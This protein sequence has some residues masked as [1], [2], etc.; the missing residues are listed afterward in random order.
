MKMPGSNAFIRLSSMMLLAMLLQQC[1]E[2]RMFEEPLSK[3]T[4][5]Y[6]IRSRFV[7][8]THTIHGRQTLEWT[9]TTA[10]PARELRFHLYMNAFKDSSATFWREAGGFPD[11]LRENRGYCL[12]KLVL[13]EDFGDVT[14][15][16]VFIQ[17]DDT[18]SHDQ[19]VVALPLRKELK[20]GQ[21]IT[22]RIEFETILPPLIERAGHHG[23]FHIAAQWYPK[24]GVYTDDG[25]RCHQYHANGEFFADFGV[26]DVVLSVPHNYEIGSTGVLRNIPEV[27]EGYKTYRLYAEDVHDFV[28][29]ADTDFQVVRRRI[30]NLRVRLLVRSNHVGEVAERILT[31]VEHGYKHFSQHVGDYPYPV[32]TVVDAPVFG[33]V[34]EYPTLFF[35]GNFDGY[36]NPPA[37]DK[38]QP[39]DNLFMERLTLHELGHQWFYGM[40]ANNEAR[41]A[42][43]D[44]GLTEYITARAFETKYGRI[45]QPDPQGKPLPVRHFRLDRYQ[46]NA[47]QIVAQPSWYYPTFGD[48]YIGSYVKPKLFLHTL[49]N[50]LGDERVPKAVQTFFKRW[51]FKHPTADDFFAIMEEVAGK[52]AAHFLKKNFESDAWLD[53]KVVAVL[54]SRVAIARGGEAILP[55]EIRFKFEDGSELT[56]TWSGET[57][58]IEYDFSHKPPLTAVTVDPNYVIEYDLN[59][60]NN[61]WTSVV[62]E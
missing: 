58:A 9:N 18:N 28:W 25:W 29:V 20:P 35:T 42:W 51:R 60:D 22:V 39:A 34:M 38:P 50:Y 3:R 1:S 36:R 41:E 7:P 49:D 17:P 40:V 54:D 26:Y 53:Y 47:S 23:D 52:D 4:A 11:A 15:D 14:D 45:M 13:L 59:R 24:I 44:E 12:I 16:L 48:Y 30:N 19:T 21:K 10:T 8:K 31:A 2:Y 43:L 32:L 6:Q 57:V 37:P 56:E 61:Y 5:N 46:Q 55:V 33:A 62:A 27:D